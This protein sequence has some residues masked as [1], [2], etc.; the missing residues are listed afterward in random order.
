MKN[1][2]KVSLLFILVFL[3]VGLSA[4]SLN[5]EGVNVN[6]Y[7][8]NN[9][10]NSEE[11]QKNNIDNNKDNNLNNNEGL[12][13]KQAISVS[14]PDLTK[15][16]VDPNNF[17]DLVSEY[18]GAII[19]T[20]KGDI[21]VKF[22]NKKSPFTVNNFLNL[23]E[24]GFYDG[25]KFHRVISNF[26]IQ[27]GDPLTK[28]EDK[29]YYGTGGPGYR[30]N[31]EINNEKL[32]SG[33]LAMANSGPNTNG[34]QFFIVVAESTPWLDGAHTNF[35]EVVGGMDVVNTIRQVETGARDIPIEDVVI[36]SIELIK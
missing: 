34:S 26:M 6:D 7:D 29:M 31:D 18:T 1:I 13:D 15:Y 36:N 20:N 14:R 16:M 25:T 23:A 32:V 33:S 10:N 8:L 28:D 27:G 11:T 30:F 2:K 9:Q 3:V 5:K 12:S 4:C 22:Y 24:L 17:K 21:E 19:K 35:G